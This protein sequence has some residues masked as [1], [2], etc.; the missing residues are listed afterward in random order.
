M[1]V[2]AIPR[3]CSRCLIRSGIG[4]PLVRSQ[5][6]VSVIA[7]RLSSNQET[8]AQ[9]IRLQDL[10]H[11]RQKLEDS[12]S[13]ASFW[14]GFYGIWSIYFALSPFSAMVPA[15]LCGSFSGISYALYREARKDMVGLEAQ[16]IELE[17]QLGI[18]RSDP[19]PE[20]Q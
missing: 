9:V 1:L 17:K 16:I 10:K 8:L 6:T 12:G 15:V 13:R 7:C 14:T 18:R 11:H 4:R 19:S 3:S 2:R 5:S 20:K